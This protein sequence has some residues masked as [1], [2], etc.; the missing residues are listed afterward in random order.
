MA[1]SLAGTN[2][3]PLAE[4]RA[5]VGVACRVDADGSVVVSS[6]HWPGP[7]V[8]DLVVHT[9]TERR[10]IGRSDMGTLVRSWEITV[11]RRREHRVIFWERGRWFVGVPKK[12]KDAPAASGRGTRP[13]GLAYE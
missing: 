9:C 8:R 4:D 5:Y 10:P 2:G 3:I 1:H 7:P 12:D 6:I 13:H 11:G